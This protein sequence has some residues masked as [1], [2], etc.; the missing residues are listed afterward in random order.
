[1]RFAFARIFAAEAEE[2]LPA[3]I[4][5]VAR[6]LALAAWLRSLSGY[7]R[8]D[9]SP[10]SLEGILLRV[11]ALSTA[12]DYVPPKEFK[13]LRRVLNKSEDA[14][15]PITYPSSE[16][17]AFVAMV[18]HDSYME[19]GA[20]F[21][22]IGNGPTCDFNALLPLTFTI[23][24]V[25]SPLAFRITRTSFSSP[26][27]FDWKYG[28]TIAF[29]VAVLYGLSDV[30]MLGSP[31]PCFF[32]PIHFVGLSPFLHFRILFAHA[33]QYIRCQMFSE[34]INSS[35][36]MRFMPIPIPF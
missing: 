14:V 20:D 12:I 1:M 9:G 13:Q 33:I 6:A 16:M 32:R 24:S 23:S 26:R 34:R 29:A 35:S 27:C 19:F 28:F 4:I 11:F 10:N 21:A 17:T 15:T 5:W 31:S 25:S 8:W 30:G 2:S 18:K 7:L 36:A 22:H 3:L